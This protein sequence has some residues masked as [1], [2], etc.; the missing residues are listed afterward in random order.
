M[1][2]RQW[3]DFKDK[4]LNLI[5]YHAHTQKGTNPQST[6]SWYQTHLLIADWQNISGKATYLFLLSQKPESQM[7]TNLS[8]RP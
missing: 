2:G 4:I 6:D 8:N 1:S 3:E 7:S 5:R